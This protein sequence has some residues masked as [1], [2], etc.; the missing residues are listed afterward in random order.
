M[1][2]GLDDKRLTS[3]NALMISALAD[4]GAAL[5]QPRYV[6]A[7]VAAAEFVLRELRDA[8]GRLLRTY[9]HG[10]AKLGGL[11]EDHAFLME[12][13]LTLYEATFD[14]RWF[15]EAR[16][17]GEQIIERFSDT[18]RG[19]FYS[20][21]AD[22]DRH[23]I[24]RRKELEDS[25]IPERRLPSAAFG[26]LR[27]AALT[28]E[29]RYEESAVG[30]LRL[31]HTIA[32]RA[33]GRLRPSAAGDRLPPR[34]GQGGRAR[35]RGHRAA[36]ARRALAPAPAPRARRR[37]RPR[38][39]AAGGPRARRRARRRLRLRALHLPTTR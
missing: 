29:H 37:R 9:N 1:R 6:E 21:P 11:L 39:A 23:L 27:L 25:P 10:R 14:E 19:G 36:R 22:H 16:A 4:A 3:W 17:L 32:P 38:G 28:G 35:R 20:T 5:E 26:L 13:L 24:A 2:P 15:S 31:L 12:A 7:A 34:A 18:E 33:P 30:G 8:D